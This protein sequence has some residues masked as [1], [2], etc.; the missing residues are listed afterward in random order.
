MEERGRHLRLFGMIFLAGI[1]VI[2]VLV[3]LFLIMRLLFGILNYIPWLSYVYMLTIL[4]VPP[5]LFIS[6]YLVFFKRTKSHPSKFSRIVS[7]PVFIAG[8]V[9][10]L[11][12]YVLDMIQFFRKGTPVISD[13]FSYNMIFLAINVALIF[14]LG[15]IQALTMPEEKDWMAKHRQDEL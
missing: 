7:Y 2:V 9:T 1:G 4:S 11:A 13:Y 15:V 8:I 14:I 12:V 6:V 3:I 5:A 10:W